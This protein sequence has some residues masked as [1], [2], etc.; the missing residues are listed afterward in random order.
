VTENDYFHFKERVDR[1]SAV[2]SQ[3]K[4]L[5]SMQSMCQFEVTPHDTNEKKEVLR[6]KE[7][8][9]AGTGVDDAGLRDCLRLFFQLRIDSLKNELEGI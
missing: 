6:F 1:Y 3:I 9:C 5:K 7:I 8:V 4:K 2:L